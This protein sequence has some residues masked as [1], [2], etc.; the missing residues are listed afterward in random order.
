M[1]IKF[2]I[3][4]LFPEIFENYLSQTIFQR[5]IEKDIIEYEIIN[6]RELSN[7]K[8]NKVDDT[9]YG[10][11]AGMVLKPEPFWE[12]FRRL[13]KEKKKKPYTIFVTPQGKQLTHQKVLELSKKEEI[14]IISGRYEGL[15]QRV[16]EKF[17][18]EEISIGD[19]VLTSGDLPTMVLIDSISRIKDGVI[20]EESYTTDSFYNGLLGFAQYTKPDKIDKMEVPEVLKSGNHKMIE[21]YRLKSSLI[22]TFKNRPDLLEEKIKDK[23]FNKIYEKILKEMM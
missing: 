11:G 5:A 3:L 6:F 23:D 19:Y 8:H 7:D 14:V 1:K 16:I 10:G 18:D 21:E 9:P 17:V 4:T 12:Y 15:D 22:N 20:N 2:N 13:R